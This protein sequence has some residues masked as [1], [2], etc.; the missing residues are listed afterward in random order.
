MTHNQ[1]HTHYGAVEYMNGKHHPYIDTESL[2]I[3]PVD[4]TNGKASSNGHYLLDDGEA[5]NVTP[6]GGQATIF[7]ETINIAKNLLGTGVFSMPGGI[8]L[9]ANDP[10]AITNASIWVIV[11]GVAF[12]YFCVLMAKVCLLTSGTTYR[13]CWIASM[14]H[15]GGLVVSFTQA[16]LPALGCLSYS[17]ILTQTFR[18]LLQ[19]VNIHLSYIVALWLITVGAIL[20][21][22]LLKNLHLLAPY[23]VIGTVGLLYTVFAM[24]KRY[25]DGSYQEGGLYYNDLTS[26]QQPLYGTDYRPWSTSVLPYVCMVYESW[27]MHYNT[28]RF[29]TELKEAS[30]PRFSQ[31]VTYSFGFSALIFLAIT[32]FGYLTFGGHTASYILNNYS[33][34]DSHMNLSRLTIGISVLTTNAMAFVGFR[35]GVLDC[36]NMPAS[37]QSDRTIDMVTITLLTII[38]VVAMFVTDLGLI[39]AIAGGTGATAMCCVFPVIMFQK[40]IVNQYGKRTAEVWFALILMIV[41]VILGIVGV[42]Q[43]ILAQIQSA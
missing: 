37:Q 15:R 41:G 10:M 24:Y 3:R 30:I 5:S 8:A 19:S 35:D 12:G 22:C 11:L 6:S 20:P 38:T 13:E 33:P 28:P 4:G 42:W 16:L 17:A 1:Q 32:A 27:V 23:S 2:L 9:Y 43:A 26:D 39:N 21:L 14:G 25:I 29:Y 40:V 31:A 36:F 7:S 34:H 18:S